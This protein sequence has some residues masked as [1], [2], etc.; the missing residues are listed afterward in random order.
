MRHTYVTPDITVELDGARLDDP[1][2]RL[3]SS[4]HVRSKL[5]C[6][7]Q[8]E[9]TFRQDLSRLPE[10]T[11]PEPGASLEVTLSDR[12]E[13]LFS[14]KVTALEYEHGP[15]GDRLIRVRGYDALYD[16]RK[17]QPVRT[18]VEMTL[19]DLAEEVAGTAGYS[20]EADEEGPLLER[21]IQFDRDDLR[22]LVTTAARY[23]YYLAPRGETL[24]L[25]SLAGLDRDPVSLT[26]GDNLFEARLE[27]NDHSVY[28]SARASG[29]DLQRTLLHA[30]DT[31]VPRNAG[32]VPEA[33]E[34]HRSGA[35][36]QR[37]LMDR[38]ARRDSE[39]EGIARGELDRTAAG[40]AVCWGVAEG[41]PGLLP[42][43]PIEVEGVERRL[44]GR[45]V[46]TDVTHRID[47]E[48]GYVCEFST[49]PP[50]LP[51]EQHNPN[52]TAGKVVDVDDPDGLGR[53]N[54]A[55]PA[56][57]D[58]ETG[59]LN[60]ILPGAGAEKGLIA[61]PQVGDLVLVLSPTA[62]PAEGVVLGG[63]FG[64]DGPSDAGVDGGSI[65]R[66]IFKT[67]GGQKIVLDDDRKRIRLQNS[68]GGF[69]QLSP[70]GVRIHAAA[71]LRIDAP[72][73]AIT[74]RGA[75]IDFEQE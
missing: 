23:G 11:L 38:A 19:A 10:L 74:I 64:P 43:T 70:G 67:P 34:S 58:C 18:H 3:L 33:A 9:L 69:V 55:L 52:L 30:G 60:V 25:V 37:A 71:D 20:V 66:F 31:D 42:G 46:L 12:N 17:A 68:S 13:T 44:C 48:H 59:W 65:E 7:A 8:C 29:W 16:L 39:S 5:S 47:S 27:L 62:E 6:P 75:T 15:S 73:N 40:M 2:I 32:G 45:Y 57:D 56:H 72:G 1:E 41:D 51:E 21:L 61:L 53:I 36:P 28:G 14:G 24:H 22:F 35:D 4:V 49:R 54:V 26:L 63:F 50:A